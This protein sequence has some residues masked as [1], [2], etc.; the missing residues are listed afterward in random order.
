MTAQERHVQIV[1]SNSGPEKEHFIVAV[2][3][4]PSI[5]RPQGLFACITW[6]LKW[7]WRL[8][9]HI[10]LYLIKCLRIG[11]RWTPNY[12]KRNH[13]VTDLTYKDRQW[14]L[15]LLSFCLWLNASS[16]FPFPLNILYT[17][18]AEISVFI[19]RDCLYMMCL[20]LCVIVRWPSIFQLLVAKEIL[21]M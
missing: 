7:P 10:P 20:T 17:V 8:R 16:V 12:H 14:L 5:C 4:R 21:I 11:W 9:Q 3:T 19:F 1:V 13:K 6:S 2:G 15:V 18:F